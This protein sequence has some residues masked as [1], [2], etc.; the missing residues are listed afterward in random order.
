MVSTSSTQRTSLTVKPDVLYSVLKYD[1]VSVVEDGAG[2]V[3]GAG[4][5]VELVEEVVAT[6][7]I[8][9]LAAALGVSAAK[10]APGMKVADVD[11][12]TPSE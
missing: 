10:T 4:V 1:C 9:T 11:R 6:A 5:G 2:V 3:A 7:S 8:L 12:T